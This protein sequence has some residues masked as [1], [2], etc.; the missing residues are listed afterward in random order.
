MNRSQITLPTMAMD[1]RPKGEGFLQRD[2][3]GPVGRS[4]M[5]RVKVGLI[6]CGHH[7]RVHLRNY[8][9][10]PESELVAIAEVNPE[11]AG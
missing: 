3:Y 6:G 2:T 7:G 8:V 1:R 5:N 11:R 10:I 4:E 9:E